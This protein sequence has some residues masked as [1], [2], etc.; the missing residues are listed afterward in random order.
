[1]VYSYL[2]AGGMGAIIV[3]FAILFDGRSPQSRVAIA[4][5]GALL[6]IAFWLVLP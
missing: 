1:M 2:A 4:S 6:M 5:L 3:A